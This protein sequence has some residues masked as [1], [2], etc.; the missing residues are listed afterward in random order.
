ME[1]RRQQVISLILQ[2]M[3]PGKIAEKLGVDRKTV[4]TDFMEW[5]KSEQ[6]TYLQIEWMQQYENMKQED[7]Q[8]AFEALTKLMMKLLEK[9]AKIELN[10]T[11][12]TTILNKTVI[13]SI[14]L[15]K[16]SDNDRNAILAAEE[17]YTRAEKTIS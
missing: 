11:N 5:A 10:L 2:R 6:A 16:L 3:T 13:P 4:Y 14:D 9:Q 15:S 8:T 12:Q 17:A 7:P 1:A